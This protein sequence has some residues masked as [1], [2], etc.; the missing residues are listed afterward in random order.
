MYWG[1]IWFFIGMVGWFLFSV[2]VGVGRAVGGQVPLAYWALLY[3]FGIVFFFSLPVAIVAEI[4]RWYRTRKQ[5]T[6]PMTAPEAEPSRSRPARAVI[7]CR[8]CGMQMP[9]DSKYCN[10]CGTRL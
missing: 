4:V 5:I 9:S 1:V 10:Q 8:Q 7:C 6:A 3:L 2:V